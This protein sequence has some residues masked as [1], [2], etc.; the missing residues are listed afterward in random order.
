MNLATIRKALAGAL[1]A[2]VAAGI[3]AY[4]DGFTSTEIATIVGAAVVAGLAVFQ[5]P[6]KPK[7][8]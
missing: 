1:A 6:N 3:T 7:E 4:P 8:N 2:A 5:I